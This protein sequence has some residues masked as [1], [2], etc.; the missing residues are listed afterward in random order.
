MTKEDLADFLKLLGVP[1]R[2]EILYF[3]SDGAEK[4]VK[5][6][7]AAL[8]QKQATISQNLI[9]LTNANILTSRREGNFR[10]YKIRYLKIMELLSSVE[11]HIADLNKNKMEDIK[12]KDI[13]DTLL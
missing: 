6:I 11:A 5:D 10:Y 8:G 2:L 3:L 4:T 12:D 9:K 13:L 1:L 7:E